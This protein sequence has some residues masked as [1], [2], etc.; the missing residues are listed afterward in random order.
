MTGKERANA[1]FTF[2]DVLVVLVVA[3]AIAFAIASTP[4]IETSD[5]ENWNVDLES[6]QM[7]GPVLTSD[8]SPVNTMSIDLRASGVLDA[9]LAR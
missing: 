5:V 6:A 9:V 1:G 4:T 8:A 7:T 3:I 2:T